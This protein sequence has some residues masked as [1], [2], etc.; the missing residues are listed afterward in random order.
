MSE[1]PEGPVVNDEVQTLRAI[2]HRCERLLKST[3][4]GY[5]PTLD[6]IEEKNVSLHDVLV[7]FSNALSA[8][9]THELVDDERDP[10]PLIVQ[11]MQAN[12]VSMTET[13]NR[14]VALAQAERAEAHQALTTLHQGVLAFANK[15]RDIGI[16][17]GTDDLDSALITVAVELDAAKRQVEGGRV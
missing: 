6:A 16:Q 9:P 12:Y 1:H 15:M 8:E 14:Q 17:V 4:L 3:I 2:V 11:I 7:D 13:M 10:L 5:G